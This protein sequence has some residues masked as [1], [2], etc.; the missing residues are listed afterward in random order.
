MS[1]QPQS[2][3]LDLVPLLAFAAICLAASL[4]VILAMANSTMGI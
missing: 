4:C 1:Y 2:H 3:K